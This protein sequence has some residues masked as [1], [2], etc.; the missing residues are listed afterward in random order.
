MNLE[1]LKLAIKNE[2][3]VDYHFES[4]GIW[5]WMIP[6]SLSDDESTLYYKKCGTGITL[7]ACI[8][9]LILD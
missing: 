3:C 8:D 4:D 7:S 1:K 6:V 9:K 5:K 2:S